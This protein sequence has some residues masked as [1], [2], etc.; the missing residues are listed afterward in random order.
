MSPESTLIWHG[1]MRYETTA[2]NIA[3]I[4]EEALVQ[5]SACGAREFDFK[6]GENHLRDGGVV[7]PLWVV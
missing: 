1:M 4:R 5:G 7:A 3:L 6:V 2:S